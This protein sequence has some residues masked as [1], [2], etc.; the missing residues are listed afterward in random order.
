PRAMI[1]A[2]VDITA[3]KEMEQRLA[4]GQR[5]ESIGR[6]AG[7]VAHDFNNLLT[8]VL[9]SAEFAREEL[10]AGAELGLIRELLDDIHH[11][12]ER[13]SRLTRQLLSF[14]RK[15]VLTL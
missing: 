14:A 9:A 6:L 1:G 10:D 15:Q 12:A 13:G 4:H 8:A 11:A 3:M 5:M 7:G 2:V